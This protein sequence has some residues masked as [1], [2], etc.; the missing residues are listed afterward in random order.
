M[1]DDQKWEAMKFKEIQRDKPSFR[2]FYPQLRYSVQEVLELMYDE[3]LGDMEYEGFKYPPF[4]M[5]GLLQRL[6]KVR[7]IR[8]EDYMKTLTAIYKYGPRG[9]YA[10]LLPDRLREAS[11]GQHLQSYFFMWGDWQIRRE[12]IKFII[13]QL[14]SIENGTNS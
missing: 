7:A 8:D 6:K 1:S 3:S 11:F 5:C 13:K 12:Y 9:S 14:D 10:D 2:I 4:G